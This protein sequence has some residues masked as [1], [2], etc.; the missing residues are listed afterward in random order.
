[1][2]RLSWFLS[3]PVAFAFL[4]NTSNALSQNH[5]KQKNQIDA[6]VRIFH[7]RY[8]LKQEDSFSK[9]GYIKGM[10][11]D[12]YKLNLQ[13]GLSFFGYTLVKQRNETYRENVMREYPNHKEYGDLY[14]QVLSDLQEGAL[15]RG[16][17]K[18]CPNVW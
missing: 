13:S 10:C 5:P 8:L 6:E 2:N 17:N 14:V 11:E 4:L 7:L 16:M 12:G 9:Y 3:I 15:R 18:T 1:M